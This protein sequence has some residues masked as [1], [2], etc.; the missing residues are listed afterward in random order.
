MRIILA[1]GS[2]RRKELMEMMGIKFDVIV[3]DCDETFEDG[4]SLEEQS[5][6]LAYIKAKTVFNE[7]SGDRII[8]GSDTMVIKDDKIYGKPKTKEE[9]I[10]MIR[11]LKDNSHKVITS[12]CVISKKDEEIKEQVDYDIAEVYFKDISDNEIETWVNTGNPYD[13]AGAYAIQ[14]KFG[15]HIN[16]IDGNYFTVVGLPIHKLYDMLKQI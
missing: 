11:E 5:K 3:S 9:A 13:K 7:T 12:L 1:S 6:R 16:K 4:L 2:P 8:I 15:V 10:Q 14:S